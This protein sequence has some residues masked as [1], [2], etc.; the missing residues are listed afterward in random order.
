MSLKLKSNLIELRDKAN[1]FERTSINNV[2]D[3]S[4]KAKYFKKALFAGISIILFLLLENGFPKEFIAFISS[5]L[6]IIIGLFITSLI[7]SFDKF[8]EKNLS[9]NPNSREK[10]WEIQSFNFAKKF[11]F[12]TGYTIILCIFS[13][14][15]LS[16]SALFFERISLNL[17][18]YNFCL[19]C[20]FSNTKHSLGLFFINTL[21]LFQRVLVFYLLLRIMF[22]TVFVVTSMTEYMLIKLEKK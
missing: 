8:Y 18:E 2:V 17:F 4:F 16:L 12:I 19:E 22:N 13:L 1:Y 10:L 7:F 20:L 11:A 9:E 14:L 21:I 5:T 3:N 6:A 15:L